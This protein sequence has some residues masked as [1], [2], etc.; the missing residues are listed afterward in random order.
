M[1]SAKRVPPTAGIRRGLCFREAPS[2]WIHPTAFLRLGLQGRSAPAIGVHTAALL[3]GRSTPERGKK[4]PERIEH[5]GMAGPGNQEEGS[6][7]RDDERSAHEIRLPRGAA[8]SLHGPRGPR[9][10]LMMVLFRV[11][12]REISSLHASRRIE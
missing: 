5:A 6:K 10:S 11:N 3:F 1:R 9:L 4:G 8:A 7:S 2:T 12:T